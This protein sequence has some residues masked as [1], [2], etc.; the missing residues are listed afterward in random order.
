MNGYER[1]RSFANKIIKIKS[2]KI[3]VVILLFVVSFSTFSANSDKE[4][5]EK[6]SVNQDIV[7]TGK[8]IDNATGEPLTGVR[9]EPV[10]MEV[11]A[12]T[13]FDGHYSLVLPEEGTYKIV[14][15]LITYKV[16]KNEAVEIKAKETV[17][18]NV[19]L[20]RL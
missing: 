10:G 9:I 19:A 4:A 15:Q 8:V 7:L 11:S 3:F 16:E 14:Y 17:R 12:F 2:M 5:K 18:H 6:A 20:H 13:D 1:L